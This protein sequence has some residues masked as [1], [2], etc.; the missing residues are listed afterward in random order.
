M[1]YLDNNQSNDPRIKLK[2]GQLSNDC[3][4][5]ELITQQWLYKSGADNLAMIVQK[6]NW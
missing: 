3:T 5:V 4:K 6:W 2:S 1:C